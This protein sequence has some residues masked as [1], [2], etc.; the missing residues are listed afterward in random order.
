[1]S[2][3]NLFSST[4]TFLA[5]HLEPDNYNLALLGLQVAPLR[6]V[7]CPLSHLLQLLLALRLSLLWRLLSN[8]LVLGLLPSSVVSAMVVRKPAH[9]LLDEFEIE[10]DEQ[11]DYVVI[12][13]AALF[14]ST[15]I[16]KLLSRPNVKLCNAVAAER[17]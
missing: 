14:T 12:K 3:S 5:S 15:I 16:S 11:D 8:L 1:M 13:H 4:W 9:L 2:D 6:Q 10:Y 17:T 7:P